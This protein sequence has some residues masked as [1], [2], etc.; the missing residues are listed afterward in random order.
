M[1]KILHASVNILI[2]LMVL[3]LILNFWAV[4]FPSGERSQCQCAVFNPKTLSLM[5]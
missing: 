4:T 1:N 2:S 5:R 3:E